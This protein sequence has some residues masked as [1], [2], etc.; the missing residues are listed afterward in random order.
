MNLKESQDRIQTLMTKFVTEIEVAKAMGN[1][2]IN[3]KSEDALIPLLSEIY[4]HTL[5]RTVIHKFT[6]QSHRNAKIL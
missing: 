6:Q 2:D 4:E 1:T 5:L 3:R